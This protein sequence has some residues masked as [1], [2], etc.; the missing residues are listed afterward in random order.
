MR[1]PY[2]SIDLDK[3]EHNARTLVNLGRMHGVTIAGVTKGTLGSPEV[4]KAM[5][6][7]GVQWLGDSRL[8]NIERMRNAGIRG[9]FLLMRSPQ[10]SE[11]E[12]TVSLAEVSLNTEYE[13]IHALSEAALKQGV[14]HNIL[15]MVDLGDLREGLWPEELLP[16]VLEVTR[17]RGIRI[18]GLGTNLTDLNGTI[19][20]PENN[21]RLVDLAEEVESRCDV[22]LEWL[23]A[24]NSSSLKLLASGR[25]PRRINHFRIG[26]GIL[27]GRETIER[28]I[29]PGTYQDAF[30]LTGEIIE[31]KR[32]PSVPSG[33]RGQD[34]FGNVP[35][36]EDRGM[37][38]R[39]I[40]NLGRQDLRLEGIAPQHPSLGIIGATSDHL[41]LET[42][43]APE[44]KVGDHVNFSPDYGALLAAMTSPFVQKS[45]R[46]ATAVMPE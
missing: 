39:A 8:E 18:L 46:R 3:V 29:W 6:R 19:P 1:T 38:T 26:E 36:L 25:L 13:V 34:A 15:L 22:H 44:L 11:V 2:L 42:T 45:I 4:A 43:A 32:K 28:E 9:P 17:M 27:L 33:E 5:R 12:R 40:V 35:I 7:G 23:S 16:L 21:Q 24:G 20:T 14:V 41:V 37:M 31:C 10:L 30:V